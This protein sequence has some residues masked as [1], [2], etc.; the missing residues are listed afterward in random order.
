MTKQK[1]LI[2]IP[3]VIIAS[4]LIY[5]WLTF[6]TTEVGPTWKHYFGLLFFLVISFSFFKKVAMTT[7]ATGI[8]LILGTF[9]LIAITPSISTF[10]FRI[11]PMTTP[12]IQGLSLGLFILYFILNMNSL[13]DIHLD[14]QEKKQI[15]KTK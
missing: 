14:Y 3:L 2:L 4:F 8:Y 11:G 9:N 6:M 1:K 12:D 13:I 15:P 10:G 7:L 5:C